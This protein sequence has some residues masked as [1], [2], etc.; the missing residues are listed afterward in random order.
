MSIQAGCSDVSI[1][2]V[3]CGPGHGISVGGLGKGGATAT[4]SDVTVQDVTFNHTMTGVRIKTW[5][6]SQA[7]G[8]HAP[9]H[10]S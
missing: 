5:Q 2:N 9:R 4:V 3:H 7:K 1:R 8:M 10:P 6:V